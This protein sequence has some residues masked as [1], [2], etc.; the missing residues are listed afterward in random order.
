MPL[1]VDHI[2]LESL[3]VDICV[4]ISG[5]IQFIHDPDNIPPDMHVCLCG[6][7]IHPHVNSNILL[8]NKL[9]DSIIKSEVRLKQI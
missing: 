4:D 2:S 3:R 1:G 6:Y 7:N 8:E 9:H 5:H